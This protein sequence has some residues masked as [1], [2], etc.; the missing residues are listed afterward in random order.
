MVTVA[1][2]LQSYHFQPVTRSR[3]VAVAVAVDIVESV[4]SYLH[5]SADDWGRAK[6]RG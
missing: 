2:V 6:G 4:K 1:M 5:L 3:D